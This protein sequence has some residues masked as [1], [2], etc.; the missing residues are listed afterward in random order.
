MRAAVYHGRGEVRV[1]ERDERTVG[2]ESVRIDVAVCGLC[3]SD[4]HEYAAGPLAIPDAQA[5]ELTGE[6]LPVTMGHEFSGRVSEVGEDVTDVG[7]GDRVTVNPAIWCGECRY[8]VAGSYQRCRYG[9]SI[10]LSGGGGG[11]AENVVV[12]ATQVVPLP[13]EVS[14]SHGAL[15]EPY[16]VALHAIRRSSIRAGSTVA[17]FGAGPIG[18]CVTELAAVA[19]ATDVVVSEPREARRAA[20]REMGATD[21]IDPAETNP[22]HYLSSELDGG[23]E[24]AFEVAGVEPTVTQSIRSTLKGG[25]VV[26]ISVFEDEVSVQPNY[27]M[28]AERTLTGSIAY[29]TGPRA[30]DGEF[31]S[32]TKLLRDGVL[33]PTPLVTSEIALNDVVADGFERLLDE[34]SD[35]IKVLVSMDDGEA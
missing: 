6:T 13:E 24:V 20:A 32:V 22:I 10:G 4:V 30:A 23:V 3:G 28:M 18:L 33:D 14:F 35:E 9:G 16:S 25:E 31:G 29:E 34:S 7:V 27:V 12:P 17:V 21:V 26:L 15:V 8:C 2:P 19:G 11:L 5:H 1:E